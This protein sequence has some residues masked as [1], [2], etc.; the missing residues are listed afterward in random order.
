MS[1]WGGVLDV[2]QYG[3][4]GTGLG[5]VV[6]VVKKVWPV[7]RKVVHIVDDVIGEEARPGVE[8]RP[9][10]M[11]RIATIEHEVRPN[12]GGSIKDAVDRIEQ[13]Q[14]L[15]LAKLEHLEASAYELGVVLNSHIAQA[16]QDKDDVY[17]HLGVRDVPDDAG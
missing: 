14:Q 6:F 1:D 15:K 9:G 12:G 5:M 10:L 8:A 17:R 4:A 11:E 3:A 2:L 16:I 7:F 13:V